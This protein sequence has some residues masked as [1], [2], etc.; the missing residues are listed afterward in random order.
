MK[1]NIRSFRIIEKIYTKGS[2]IL[3]LRKLILLILL[4]PAFAF[5]FYIL[6]LFVDYPLWL[7]GIL[8]IAAISGYFVNE[9][10]NAYVGRET[11][12]VWGIFK[13][14]EYPNWIVQVRILGGKLVFPLLILT[15][16]ADPIKDLVELKPINYSFNYLFFDLALFI[17]FISIIPTLIWM[18]YIRLNDKES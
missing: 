11:E 1:P 3:K 4:L 12:K 13:G 14:I 6:N 7:L 18:F 15:M 17:L 10:L 8:S 2:V 16:G 9:K 5:S